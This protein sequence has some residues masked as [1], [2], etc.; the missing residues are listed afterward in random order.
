MLGSQRHGGTLALCPRGR[1]YLCGQRGGVSSIYRMTVTREAL[2]WASDV[3]R[4]VRA[5]G[6]PVGKRGE[7]V[8]KRFTQKTV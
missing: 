8:S 3:Q 2:R 5:L 6:K 4:W 7:G 1:L